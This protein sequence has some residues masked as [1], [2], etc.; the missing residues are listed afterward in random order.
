[1]V[2]SLTM[3]RP[4]RGRVQCGNGLNK[5]GERVAHRGV[6]CPYTKKRKVTNRDGLSM[7][8]CS[9]QAYKLVVEPETPLNSG[10]NSLPNNLEQLTGD[11][12]SP[13]SPSCIDSA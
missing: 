8:L 13:F 4:N 7:F 10:D 11:S 3:T 9:N 1:M 5:R 2:V 12:N 6:D